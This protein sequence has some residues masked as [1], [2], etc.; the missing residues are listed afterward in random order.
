MNI[1]NFEVVKKR[2]EK[3]LS[4]VDL[5]IELEDIN[6]EFTIV[7]S[8]NI[9]AQDSDDITKLTRNY[10]L[11]QNTSGGQIGS[12][13]G[14]YDYVKQSSLVANLIY[15]AKYR[16]S[17]VTNGWNITCQKCG[18]Q[19]HGPIW[20]NSPKLCEKCGAPYKAEDKTKKRSVIKYSIDSKLDRE[21]VLKSCT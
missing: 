16:I 14:S 2:V 17:S 7:Y 18:A 12:P 20:R 5:E 15:F 19:Q 4:N 10:W 1:E 13:W 9:L 3:L 21:T 8:T 11:N 6:K